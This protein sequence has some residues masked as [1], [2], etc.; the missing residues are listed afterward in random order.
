MDIKYIQAGKKFHW[1]RWQGFRT[2]G[3]GFKPWERQ[4]KVK[5]LVFGNCFRTYNIVVDD[6]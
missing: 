5:K 1:L 3:P 6:A 4:E 2:E